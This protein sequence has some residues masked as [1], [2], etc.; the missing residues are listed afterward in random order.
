M[1]RATVP[2][3]PGA[4]LLLGASGTDVDAA[5][6]VS[7]VLVVTHQGVVKFASDSTR[8][9]LADYVGSAADNQLP[10]P[11]VEWLQRS[12]R[13]WASGPFVAQRKGQRLVLHVLVASDPGETVVGV[14]EHTGSAG[15][16]LHRHGL[17]PR[18]REVLWWVTEG[19]TNREIGIILGRS[20]RTV[21]IHLNNVYRK[22]G[23]ETRTAAATLAIRT[24]LVREPVAVA[25]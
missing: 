4:S 11:V 12:L 15:D 2:V 6:S 8:A 21:Q 5:G 13:G 17:T 25:S 14:E 7:T 9:L 20:S 18:E 10:A 22:L 19:K 1:K 3:L 24:S 23:V 16:T